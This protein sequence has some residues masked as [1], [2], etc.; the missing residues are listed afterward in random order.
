MKRNRTAGNAFELQV[1]KK[2]IK[3]FP[4][5]LTSRNES[6]SMDAKK[7][8][9][10]NT[11]PFHF[12]CKLSVNTPNFKILD[13]MPEGK[14]VLIYG[15]VVKANKNFMQKETYAILKLDDFLELLK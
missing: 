10:C 5:I 3:F 6:R 14:N 15:K 2:F 13:E 8:D 1:L 11:Y 12:Q 9:F 4:D 7:V